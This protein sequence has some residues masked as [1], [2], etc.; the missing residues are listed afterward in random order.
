MS[1]RIEA[2]A[3][4]DVIAWARRMAGLELEDAARKVQ[5]KPDRLLSWER[6]HRRPSITQ[7][8][9]LADIYRR[10]LATF[11]LEQAPPDDALPRDFR[12]FDP[13]AA[14]PLSPELRLAI[15]DARAR[16]EAALE[17]FDELEEEPPAFKLT[18]RMSEDPER[19]GRRLR[20]GVTRGTLP[21]SGDKR[22]AFNFWRGVAEAA[23][24]LVF[25]SRDVDK[26][27]MRGFSISDRPLPMVVLNIKDAYAGRSFSLMHELAHILLD[28]GGLCLLDDRGPKTDIRLTEAFCNHVAG[29]ALLPADL[30]LRQPEVPPRRVRE[31]PDNAL[32]TIAWR[33]GTSSEAV[34]RRLVILDRVPLAFYQRKRADYQKEYD[35]PPSR[36]GGFAPPHTMSVATAGRLFTRLVLSAYDENRITASDV[37]EHL[38]VRLKHL[39]QIRDAVRREPVLGEPS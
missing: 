2:L 12:R 30:L 39:E 37:S 17:L 36:Q 11:Y 18:A 14:E 4:P 26:Q 29:A 21:P 19:A 1:A 9:K 34:L 27:E 28:R 32:D 6:G 23:G 25:Q 35:R 3:N 38:G 8:R 13:Q 7:L 16:R 10:S 24:V 33:L 31:F 5:V 15:R 20:Y 22:L